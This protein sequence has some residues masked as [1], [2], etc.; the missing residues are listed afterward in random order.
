MPANAIVRARIDA[1][2]KEE[3]TAIYAAAG[4]T[5][6]DAFRMMLMR[7]VADRALPFDPLIPNAETVEAMKAARRR[8]LVVAILCSRMHEARPSRTAL[9]VAMRRAAHQLYDVEPLVLDD[10]FAVPI[11]GSTYAEELR[12]TPNPDPDR[13][14]RPFSVALRAFLVARS[15]YAEDELHASVARGVTQYV[16]LGAGLDT[17]AYRNPSPHLHVFEVDHPATQQWK[18]DLVTAS[19]LPLPPRLT[20]VP[21]DFESQS[22][23]AQLLAA[24]HNPAIPTFFSWLGVV[25]YLSLSAFRS[26][27]NLIA[28]Q[29]SGTGLVLDYSQPRHVL[30]PA[31]QLA[32]D[33]LASRVRLAGEPFQL[34]FTPQ[35]MAAELAA[36]TV[37][38]D[39]G[40]PEL[41][42]RYFTNRTDKLKLLGIAGHLLSAW[43]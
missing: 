39:L 23:T 16:L 32:H 19:N 25:P 12:R 28:C 7:T 26:T 10:P 43:R 35:E 40:S 30:P 31:E 42:A 36:F 37:L 24:G 13:K 34:F 8:E 17:F 4:L 29:P 33:S 1:R 15:R 21:V 14:P 18:R 3:A 38:E 27:L 20:F 2:V 5:L 6:S 41:N 22:L 11:L 9:R